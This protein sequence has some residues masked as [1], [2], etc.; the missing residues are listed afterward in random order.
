MIEFRCTI[1]TL[2]EIILTQD[3]GRVGYAVGG[4]ADVD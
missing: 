2:S 3:G 1:H 4:A